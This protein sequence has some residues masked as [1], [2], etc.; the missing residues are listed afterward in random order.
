MVEYWFVHLGCQ[1]GLNK[2]FYINLNTAHA[3]TNFKLFLQLIVTLNMFTTV[4]QSWKL[5]III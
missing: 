2:L 5:K 4:H 3:A 1:L